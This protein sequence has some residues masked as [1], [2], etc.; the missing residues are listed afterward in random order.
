VRHIDLDSPRWSIPSS[1]L[2]GACAHRQAAP[3]EAERERLGQRQ[4]ELFAALAARDADRT[5]ALF[6]DD[7]LLH[8]AG[9]PPIQ[10]RI[11]IREFYSNVFG[12]LSASSA[13]PEMTH[14]S[15]S[16]DLA[17]GVGRVANAFRGPQGPVEYAGKY[18]LVWR[19]LADD[20]VIVLY[21]ISSNQPEAAR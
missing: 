10:G 12:F 20:W 5:A 16:G 3:A 2:A 11:A 19:K 6:A 4:G 21:G 18:L 8:V 7:A 1:G 17:Y 15:D 9:M 14:I 13:T